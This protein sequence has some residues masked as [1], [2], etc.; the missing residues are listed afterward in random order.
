LTTWENFVARRKIDVSLFLSHN[1]ITSRESFIDHLNS[2]GI[3][4]PSEEAMNAIF[5]PQPSIIE[6]FEAPLIPQ[7]VAFTPPRRNTNSKNKKW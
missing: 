5:P 1:S 3:G 2:R 4:L 6:E 7:P